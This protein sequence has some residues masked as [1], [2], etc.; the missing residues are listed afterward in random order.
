MNYGTRLKLNG[1]ESVRML[2]KENRSYECRR[3]KEHP[4]RY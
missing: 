4:T 3:M 2:Q 1:K